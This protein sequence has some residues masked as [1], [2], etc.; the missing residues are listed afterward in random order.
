MSDTAMTDWVHEMNRPR[1]PA[2]KRRNGVWLVVMRMRD[3]GLM[4]E[5]LDVPQRIM[6]DER[7]VDML[8]AHFHEA[9]DS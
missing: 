1:T 2:E 3:E 9:K 6:N 8:V 4:R 7:A 5:G